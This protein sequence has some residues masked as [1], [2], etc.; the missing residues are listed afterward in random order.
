LI[1]SDDD[2]RR[3]IISR[4][5]S[6][7][8][9]L[10]INNSDEGLEEEQK[11]SQK[12]EQQEEQHVVQPLEQM[13]A[14]DVNQTNRGNSNA[15]PHLHKLTTIKEEPR[16]I[17]NQSNNG[18]SIL[19]VL[20]ENLDS[21]AGPNNSGNSCMPLPYLDN[22]NIIKMLGKGDNILYQLEDKSDN[23]KACL[24]IVTKK[25]LLKEDKDDL[26]LKITSRVLVKGLNNP[27][28]IK[29]KEWWHEYIEGTEILD[30][31]QNTKLSE[32]FVVRL[33]EKLVSVWMYLVQN[34]FK[35][36]DL[37]PHNIFILPDGTV[38]I[39]DFYYTTEFKIEKH[40]RHRYGSVYFVAPEVMDGFVDA[41]WYDW[42]AWNCG[43]IAYLLL[44]GKQFHQV[45]DH[46]KYQDETKDNIVDLEFDESLDEIS[47]DML[48]LLKTMISV[49]QFIRSSLVDIKNNKIF[50]N[51]KYSPEEVNISDP[52]NIKLKLKEFQGEMQMYSGMVGMI[53]SWCI[54]GK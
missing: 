46:Q 51:K 2:V 35:F 15:Q 14:L 38:K 11:L 28:L 10:F 37:K 24:R 23:S 19:Q 48:Y 17:N 20:G 49:D 44:T 30:Y 27:N 5:D 33:V 7:E 32:E 12:E 31:I 21:V 41:D 16:D 42:Y 45:F 8:K 3:R 1:E 6:P 4:K 52:E 54:Y 40:V 47:G 22:Y 50:L 36:I 53:Y 29:F 18:I 13:D 9:P 26:T 25:N 43:A 39:T 34:E